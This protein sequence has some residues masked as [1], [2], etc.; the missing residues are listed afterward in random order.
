M[1]IH[2]L[3][4]DNLLSDMLQKV[5]LHS[6]PLVFI[7]SSISVLFVTNTVLRTSLLMLQLEK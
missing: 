4:Y 6:Q 1:N 2:V 3:Y 7:F 5:L